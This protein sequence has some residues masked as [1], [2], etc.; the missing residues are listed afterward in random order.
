MENI[1]I[2]IPHFY[3]LE[4]REGNKVLNVEI[5]FRERELIFGKSLIKKR[6]SPYSEEDIT[7]FHKDK[8]YAYYIELFRKR[9]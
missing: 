3:C 5:D 2:D 7:S 8:I 1:E 4:Y 6:E 9:I